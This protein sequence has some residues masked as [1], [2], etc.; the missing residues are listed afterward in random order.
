MTITTATPPP[1]HRTP[2]APA[3][4]LLTGGVLGASLAALVVGSVVQSVPLFVTGFVLPA[5]YGLVLFLAGIPRRFRE[6]AVAPRTA[7][8]VIDR[9]E[10]VGGGESSDV[11]VKFTLTVLPDDGSAFRVEITEG[12]NLVDLPDYR[13]RG[14]VVVRYP[15]DRPWRVRVVKRPTPQWEE[16]AAA[17]RF[18]AVPGAARVSEPPKGCAFGLAVLLGL[19]LGAA[20]VVLLFR[21]D[22]FDR[23]DTAKPAPAARPSVSATSSTTVVSSASA[24]VTLGPG[25]S[26]LDKG[27]LD[28]AVASLAEGGN[29]RRALTVVVQERLLSVVFVPTGTPTP[30]LDLRALP[31]GR[32][33]ALVEEAGSTL[34]VHSPQTWQIVTDRLTGPVVVRVVVTGPESTASLEADGQGK[35]VRR[36]PA[37]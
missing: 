11:P 2:L 12:V 33:P 28:R 37:R 26:F 16:R 1:T 15:A 5:V 3:R 30:G 36:T 35:V 27:A 25:Q 4:G 20:A 6:A 19:L 9:L 14:V 29:T 17:A 31:Y 8:A 18:D 23:D 34:G 13:P 10:A 21:A 24:T 7:L 22:L 32:F